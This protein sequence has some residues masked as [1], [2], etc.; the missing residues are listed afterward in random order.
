M[1]R[2]EVSVTAST[3]G[4][5]MWN[6]GEPETVSG[7]GQDAAGSTCATGCHSSSSAEMMTIQLLFC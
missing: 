4:T 5:T 6:I 2:D 1:T 7:S 3:P